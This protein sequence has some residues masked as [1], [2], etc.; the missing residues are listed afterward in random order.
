MCKWTFAWPAHFLGYMHKA[1]QISLLKEVL[2]MMMLQQVFIYARQ[3]NAP[4]HFRNLAGYTD[5]VNNLTQGVQR[6]AIRIRRSRINHSTVIYREWVQGQIHVISVA[7]STHHRSVC[8]LWQNMLEVLQAESFDIFCVKAGKNVDI[9]HNVNR[10]KMMDVPVDES[11][12]FCLNPYVRRK[13]S[14]KALENRKNTG[15]HHDKHLDLIRSV[16]KCHNY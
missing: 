11:I 12:S 5:M 9:V 13:K 16:G 3:V 14:F 15:F 8:Y 1:N 6:M 4:R 2:G 7:R 10:I